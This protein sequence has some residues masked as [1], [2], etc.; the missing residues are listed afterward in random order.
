M[1]RTKPFGFT[2]ST[3]HIPT[4]LRMPPLHSYIIPY[5]RNPQTPELHLACWGFCWLLPFPSL[6]PAG[7]WP[8]E[9]LQ[10]A[11]ASY[12]HPGGKRRGT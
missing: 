4:E 8:F 3:V 9:S 12:G 2:G 5:Q 6:F 11:A 10:S 7:T 1:I